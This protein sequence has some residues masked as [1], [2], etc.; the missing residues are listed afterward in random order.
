MRTSIVTAGLLLALGS[1][2]AAEPEASDPWK[3]IRFFVGEWAG[4][5]TGLG[6]R[7][8]TRHRYEPVLEQQFIRMTTRAVFELREGDAEP[9]THED[10]GFFSYDS[11][12]RKIMLRQ[13]LSEG[14]VNTYVLDEV[15]DDAR[16]LIFNTVS[17]EGASGT[18]ARLRYEILGDDEY[19][20]V[21]ELAPPGRDFFACRDL[22]MR[23]VD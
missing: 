23:R 5:G 19:R 9:E 20:L 15:G 7:A 16:L 6:G 3:V 17:A 2:W 13:F 10:I 8:E 18:R 14:F 11:E 12:R 21:L 4:T 1:S 22:V